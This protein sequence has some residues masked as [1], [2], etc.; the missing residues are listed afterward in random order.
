MPSPQRLLQAGEAN[1]SDHEEEPAQPEVQTQV[2]QAMSAQPQEVVAEAIKPMAWSKS[3]K[4]VVGHICQPVMGP[5]KAPLTQKSQAPVVHP[6]S[7]A[8]QA[9]PFP[10]REVPSSSRRSAPCSALMADRGTTSPARA[11]SSVQRPIAVRKAP[12]PLPVR[13]TTPA[14]AAMKI[15]SRA[16]TPNR[17]AMP[18]LGPN[19]PSTPSS[20]AVKP[21]PNAAVDRR[22]QVPASASPASAP[23]A[24]LS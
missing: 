12:I 11:V 14:S 5:A 24:T 18:L 16:T 22:E 17:P 10:K 13:Q 1:R 3:F 4:E 8:L 20:T 7:S 2:P 19:V 9:A 21:Q 23:P 15:Q 6:S